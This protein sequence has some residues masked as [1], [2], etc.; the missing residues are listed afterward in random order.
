AVGRVLAG[1]KP[2]ST[3][4][5]SEPYLTAQRSS[6][7]SMAWGSRTFILGGY[8]EDVSAA[9]LEALVAHVAHL[10]GDASISVTAMGGAIGRVEDDAM[11]F[12]GRTVPFDVSPDS[13]WS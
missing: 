11:A 8:V 9:A 1:P 5:T 4:A 3:T 6:D 12:T 13:G 10:P 2:L 7:L